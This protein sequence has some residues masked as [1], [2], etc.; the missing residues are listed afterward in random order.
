V[1]MRGSRGPGEARIAALP[2]KLLAG[3]VV[4]RRDRARPLLE[5]GGTSLLA[6]SVALRLSTSAFAGP[7]SPMATVKA[8]PVKAD[9]K[10]AE[11]MAFS[12]LILVAPGSRTPQRLHLFPCP[13]SYCGKVLAI[14]QQLVDADQS[15]PAYPLASRSPSS[16]AEFLAQSRVPGSS[17]SRRRPMIP[18]WPNYLAVSYDFPHRIAE[19]PLLVVHFSS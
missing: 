11:L 15:N 4:G 19:P 14:V 2:G 12:S 5:F 18:R 8:S 1:K 7:V 10:I 13:C 9:R 3:R 17:R 16:T 6:F